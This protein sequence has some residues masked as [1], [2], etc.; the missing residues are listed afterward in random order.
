MTPFD[1]DIILF[2]VQAFLFIFLIF[3]LSSITFKNRLID[4]PHTPFV[5]LE[6]HLSASCALPEWAILFTQTMDPCKPHWRAMSQDIIVK[7]LAPIELTA[8]TDPSFDWWHAL[9]LSEVSVLGFLW[10][11]G[12]WWTT[13][14]WLLATLISIKHHVDSLHRLKQWC[15]R[16]SQQASHPIHRRDIRIWYPSS[17]DLHKYLVHC[18]S[19]LHHGLSNTDLTRDPRSRT[20]L[21][22]IHSMDFVSAFV[23]ATYLYRLA[24]MSSYLKDGDL[25]A[26][27]RRPRNILR[28]FSR[29]D[30]QP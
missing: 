26:Y 25:Y 19:P 8:Y 7:I 11:R 3:H 24:T 14:K 9:W 20:A 23:A 27:A 16:V 12:T 4:L 15:T 21:L 29:D 6:S 5:S 2:L 13:F 28:N 1:S 18:G 10:I 17:F 22:D 30:F